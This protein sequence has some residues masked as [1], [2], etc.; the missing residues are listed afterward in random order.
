VH[1]SNP[2]LISLLVGVPGYIAYSFGGGF[3]TWVFFS[4]IVDLPILGAFWILTSD[5]APRKN[6]K[7][8]LPDKPIEH[9]LSFHKEEDRD[10]YYG[11]KKIPLETFQEKYFDGEVS[12]K[13]DMLEV[14]EMRH[15]WANFRF[16]IGNIRHFLFG[17]LPEAIMHTRSQGELHQTSAANGFLMSCR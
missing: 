16:T 1:F 2:L 8:R 4:L 11:R 6:E 7:V 5:F 12:V 14:L 3:K 17:F 13:G 9:Y 15:D 10:S